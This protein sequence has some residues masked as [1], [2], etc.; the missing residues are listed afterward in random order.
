MGT[1]SIGECVCKCVHDQWIIVAVAYPIRDYP[2]VI[3]VEDGAEID[4]VSLSVV[5][6]F[7]LGDVSEPFLVRSTGCEFPVEYIVRN[8]CG[9]L[10]S[11][12]AAVLLPLY[13]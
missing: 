11:S 10:G 2:S 1:R 5:I 12:R 13:R 3:Q 4:L 7:E 9:I 6:V 8:M